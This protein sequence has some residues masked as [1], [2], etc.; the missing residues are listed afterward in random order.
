MSH[1]Y[2]EDVEENELTT[3][4][5]IQM[6][7]VEPREYEPHI[8]IVTK[9]G[10][11]SRDD[12]GKKKVEETWVR[13]TT[14]KAPGFSIQKEK[15]TFMGAKWSLMNDRASTFSTQLKLM[16]TKDCDKVS[17]PMQELDPS[18][19][20]SCLQ[21]CVKLLRNQKVFEGLQ[22]MIDSCA[23]KEVPQSDLRAVKNLH[24]HKKRMGKEMRFTAQIGEY[25]MDKII[26]DLGSDANM[27]PKKTWE[28]MGRPKL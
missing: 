22:E 7:T 16:P 13:K 27:L 10:A 6:M 19:L 28:L 21:I 8:N 26:L 1:I 14:E 18:I 2:H 5:N 15:E 3:H 17:T 11:T 20:K 23:N 25:D 12:K 4:K 24:W 9:S